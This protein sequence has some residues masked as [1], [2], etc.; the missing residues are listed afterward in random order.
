LVTAVKAKL[1]TVD[2]DSTTAVNVNATGDG[3]VTLTGQARNAAQRASYD[4]AAASVNGV[5]RVVDHLQINPAMRGPKEQFS[6]VALGA[7]VAAN[8]AA[9][10]GVNAA[11]VKPEVRDGVV[12]LSGTVPSASI[13]TTILNA[14]RKTTGVKNVVDRIEVKP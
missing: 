3:V 5:K 12:T 4:S 2:A 1:A 7:K 9:Q 8:I 10:A 6:D 13:K 11:S 14:V